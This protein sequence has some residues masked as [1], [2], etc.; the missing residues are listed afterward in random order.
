MNYPVKSL[1]IGSLVLITENKLMIKNLFCNKILSINCIT[2]INFN[3]FRSA[4][5]QNENL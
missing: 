3:E 5:L 2:G 4:L 1:K